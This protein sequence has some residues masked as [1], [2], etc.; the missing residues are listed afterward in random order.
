MTAA[1]CNLQRISR[2]LPNDLYFSSNGNICYILFVPNLPKWSKPSA[3]KL[4]ILEP[5]KNSS[6][7]SLIPFV[8][9]LPFSMF[10]HRVLNLKIY[11]CLE[12]NRSSFSRLS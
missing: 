2:I 9:N 8:E 7:G 1:A 6:R 12:D 4:R 10:V 5:S 3:S 11:L